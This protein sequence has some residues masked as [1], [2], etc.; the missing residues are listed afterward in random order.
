MVD[1]PGFTVVFLLFISSPAP[2]SFIVFLEA[3]LAQ[4]SRELGVGVRK[5]LT[6]INVSNF[7][8][9]LNKIPSL[10]M[11]AVL[12]IYVRYAINCLLYY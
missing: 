11:D 12:V 7:Y 8:K 6:K 3:M 4:G 9:D 1:S 10:Y 5:K 2:K